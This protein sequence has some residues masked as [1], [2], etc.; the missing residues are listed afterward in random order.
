MAKQFS[1][2][3]YQPK[4]FKDKAKKSASQCTYCGYNGHT[5]EK[6]FQLHGYPPGWNGPKGKRNIAY[7]HAV[8]TTPEA[9]KQESNEQPKVYFTPEEFKKIMALA[10]L[11]QPNSSSQNNIQPSVNHV[12]SSHFSGKDQS[13]KKMIG[14]ALEKEGLYHLTQD[15]PKTRS[16][17]PI[18]TSSVPLALCSTH[19]QLDIWHCRLGHVAM[20]MGRADPAWPMKNKLGSSIGTSRAQARLDFFFLK[21]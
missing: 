4:I 21:I 16:C 15:L 17:T 7:A 20:A 6:C 10:S 11:S 3:N 2:Q 1:Q 12:T 14:I 5:V 8:T 19:R 18:Q 9:H 13:M